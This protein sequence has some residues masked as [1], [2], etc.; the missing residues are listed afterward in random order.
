MSSDFPLGTTANMVQVWLFLRLM[1]QITNK[2]PKIAY[3]KNVNCHIYEPQLEL[4]P[5]QLS[6]EMLAEPTIDINPDIK[7][8]EDVETWVTI[9]DFIVDYPEFH[10]PIKYPFS[11]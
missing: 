1:A 7:T 6:R 4:I 5:T 3:H 11:V 10:P 2:N 9:D 8:L